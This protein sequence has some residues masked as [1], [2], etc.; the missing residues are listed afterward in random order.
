MIFAF[1]VIVVALNAMIVRMMMTIDR[2]CCIAN[3]IQSITA[4]VSLKGI[5]IATSTRVLL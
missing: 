3:K 5:V 4:V 2:C 1:V